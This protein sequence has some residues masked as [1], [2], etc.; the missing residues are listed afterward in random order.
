[1][2]VKYLLI[3]FLISCY[4]ASA[5]GTKGEVQNDSLSIKKLEGVVVYANRIPELLKLSTSATSL[6]IPSSTTYMPRKIAADEAL[7]L[8]PGVRIDNQANG[9]RL[10]MSIRG[11]GILTERGLR[12]ITVLVD[13]ITVNDPSGFAPD[14]YDVDWENVDKIEIMRGPSASIYG[15]GGAAGVLNITTENGGDKPFG[16][17]IYTSGGSNGFSKLFGQID[18]TTENLNYRLSASRIGGNGWRDH[19]GIWCD[20]ISEKLNWSASDKFKLTQILSITDYFNQNAEG[21]SLDQL[22]QNPKQAN[23][24]SRPFN[25]YQKTNRVTNSVLGNIKFSD[26]NDLQFSGFLRWWKY[27]ETSNKAAQYRNF[28]DPG[29]SIQYN[30]HFG[31]ENVKNHL[32]VGTDFQWQTI[33]ENKFRSLADTTRKESM[34][35]DNLEDTVMLANQVISQGNVGAFIFDKLN[36]GENLNVTFSLRYDNITNQLQDNLNRQDTMSLSGNANFDKVTAKLG[37]AYS[38]APSLTCYADW[39]Q[40][41]MPPATEELASNPVSFAGFNKNLQP[42]TSVGEELGFR[43]FVSDNLF[44]DVTGFYMTTNKDFFRFKLY[45]AR[46]NQEVFYGNAG[47]SKRY[48]LETYVSYTPVQD[49]YLQ[50]AY[51]YSHFRYDSPDSLNG[52]W[53]PNSPEHQLTMDVQYEPVKDIIIGANMETQSKWSIY[54]DVEHK[55]LFQDGYKIFSARL[56]YNFILYNM[57]FNATFFVKNIGN[58]IY[59]GFTEPDPDGNCYQPAPGREYFLDLRI[60]F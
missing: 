25:E 51:T 37:A 20:N 27:K 26:F 38:F 32:S 24:D 10:H 16:G 36:V 9:S 12:G 45:P 6:V 8:V 56:G 33:Y 39:G 14:L 49:L 40:G 17:K 3:L 22:L 59:M 60:L 28:I 31:N 46:G 4:V 53:V 48:G 5:E 29:G 1:M 7:M 13:G 41:F 58:V 47:S 57:H 30:M 52:N 43:G 11:Q 21:L 50:A 23:P 55:N 42:A 19:S 34:S 15:G 54:T 18:G 2:N 44:Y 35:Q